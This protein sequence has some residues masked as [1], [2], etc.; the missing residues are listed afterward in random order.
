M[1]SENKRQELINTFFNH[2]VDLSK[3]DTIKVI[4]DY[5]SETSKQEHVN[6]WP[7]Q[8]TIVSGRCTQIRLGSGFSHEHPIQAWYNK[9]STKSEIKAQVN[10]RFKTDATGC[11]NEN[12]V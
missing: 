8:L 3:T 6:S 1:N 7:I 12:Y 9:Y 2:S 5:I 10:Y 4:N 11:Y